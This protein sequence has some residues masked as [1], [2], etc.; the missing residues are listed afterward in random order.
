MNMEN[1]QQFI[2]KDYR[3][4]I[5]LVIYDII[6]NKRRN[7]MVKCLEGYGLRVQKSAFEAYLSKRKYEKLMQDASRIIDKEKDSLRIYLLANHTSVR[8]W[9]R[10][11]CYK[12]DVVIF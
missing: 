10:G 1:K 5:V 4:Y 12:D 8:S 7:Y 3:R 9:G 11:E 2:A 6:D